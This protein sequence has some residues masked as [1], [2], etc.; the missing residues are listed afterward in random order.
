MVR[1]EKLAAIG[2][3]AGGVAHDLR[4]PLGAIKN[5][6]YYLNRKLGTNEEAKENPRIGQ[7]LRI[8]EDEV[9]HSNQIITDLLSFTRLRSLSVS[10]VNLGEIIENTLSSVELKEQTQIIK[11]FDV[12]LPEV[13]ADGDQLQRVFA[14]L[15]LNAQDAMPEG[16]VLTIVTRREDRFAEVMFKDSGKGIDDEVMKSIFDPL[17]TTKTKGTGLG[18]AVCQQVV[19]KHGGTIQATS[20]N[21]D[22]ATFTIKLPLDTNGQE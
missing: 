6:S 10:N 17:F 14:N 15:T 3:L 20:Q 21:G 8:I 11:E 9:D 22:G 1:T 5:A 7:F 4:N 16:G 19:A 18:L 2:Q 12:E 13:L